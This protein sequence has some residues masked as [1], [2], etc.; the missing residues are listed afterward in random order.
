MNKRK[1]RAKE[2]K[3]EREGEKGEEE[4]GAWVENGK[5]E[6]WQRM[7]RWSIGKGLQRPLG[8][9]VAVT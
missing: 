2:T 7:G 4:K 1:R 8:S 3:R 9:G 5:V 6:H